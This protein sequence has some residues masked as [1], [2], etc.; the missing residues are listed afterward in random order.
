M[1]EHISGKFVEKGPTHIIVEANGL[2]YRVQVSLTTSSDV[3]DRAEGTLLT[4]YSV[5]VDV[6]SGESKHQL[7]GFSTESERQ[8]FKLLIGVSGIS[9]TIAQT[10]LS[11]FKPSELQDIVLS[12]DVKSM[13]AVKGVGP[14]MAQKAINELKDKLVKEDVISTPAS[15]GGN[16]LRSE[17]LS[18]LTALGF[19]RS[20][21]VK[22]I[23]QILKD[24][25]EI[26]KVE[27]LIKKALNKL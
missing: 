27:V 2:G 6:R 22:T 3:G 23:N 8:L 20:S 15:N 7:F 18:A 5:S 13:T 14:K 9:S 25:A 12:Q 26:D 21:S 19:D 4:H 24:D 1:I 11:T 17:A 10:I 16:S